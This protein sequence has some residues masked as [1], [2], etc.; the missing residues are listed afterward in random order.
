MNWIKD[1]LKR[2]W[3]WLT[4]LF[5]GG[6]IIVQIAGFPPTTL[7]QELDGKNI[8][9]DYVDNN[10]QE[11]LIIKTNG[12]D[13]GNNTPIYMSIE[14]TT[15]VDQNINIVFSFKDIETEV[16]DIKELVSNELVP[17]YASGTADIIRMDRETIWSDKSRTK[18][19]LK[20]LDDSIKSKPRVTK[21]STVGSYSPGFISFISA[22]ETKYYRF[23]I[24]APIGPIVVVG[25]VPAP[26]ETSQEWYVEV[27]GDN[28]GYGHNY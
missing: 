13:F 15:S 16:Y 3:K 7:N 25:S 12:N 27:F 4:A 21:K 14:N 2:G 1:K 20:I 11:N 10:N 23:K 6:I 8:S 24:T 28:G 5:V 26:Y 19:D 22:G 17:K 18:P 9:F